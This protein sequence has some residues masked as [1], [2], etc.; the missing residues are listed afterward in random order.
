MS[1]PTR[2]QPPLLEDGY[3]IEPEP[4]DP[5]LPD[6]NSTRYCLVSDG[7]R[8]GCSVL[9]FLVILAAL[10]LATPRGAPNAGE[11]SSRVA[12][13]L[14]ARSALLGAPQKGP[15]SPEY[16]GAGIFGPGGAPLARLEPTDG[17]LLLLRQAQVEPQPAVALRPTAT[18]GS[19][20][21]GASSVELRRPATDAVSEPAPFLGD[22]SLVAFEGTISYADRSFGPRYLALPELRGTVADICGP[23]GCV[24]RASTD[25]GPDQR[26]HPDRIAD[27]SAADFGLVCGLPLAFGVCPGT[28]TIVSR[29]P[30]PATER[31]TP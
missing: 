9:G 24:R 8:R 25:F 27:V 13:S 4:I 15:A 26:V 17:G 2:P 6:T 5:R 29:P 22:A 21:G 23:A 16:V 31:E 19:A 1:P 11:P 20:P 7:R 18:V 14:A 28:V 10:S 12:P 30:L 3:L